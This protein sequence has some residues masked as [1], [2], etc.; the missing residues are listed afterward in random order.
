MFQVQHLPW[1]F[2]NCPVDVFSENVQKKFNVWILQGK[3]VKSVLSDV[4]VAINGYEEPSNRL[5]LELTKGVRRCRKFN[6]TGPNVQAMW[7]TIW[8]FWCS[9]AIER[10]VGRVRMIKLYDLRRRTSSGAKM[11]LKDNCA[12]WRGC[13]CNG[14][15]SESV[16]WS[17]CR[18]ACGNKE[19]WR[20]AADVYES[21]NLEG[22]VFNSIQRSHLKQTLY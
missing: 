22:A 7:R 4:L 15:I 3:L 20:C 2:S 16:K 19:V 11:K 21:S 9:K 13:R 18:W 10:K 1:H 12:V 8:Q 17:C 6:W 5:W 14:W